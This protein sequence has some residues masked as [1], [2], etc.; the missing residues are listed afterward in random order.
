L[1]SSSK[2]W[3]D[4][5]L[6]ELKREYIIFVHRKLQESALHI[7]FVLVPLSLF[8]FSRELKKLPSDQGLGISSL[9]GPAS[10]QSASKV[11]SI[12]EPQQS[13]E[14]VKDLVMEV[15]KNEVMEDAAIAEKITFEEPA[16][17]ETVDTVPMEID[18]NI[19]QSPV[20]KIETGLVPTM[21]ESPVPKPER[22]IETDAVELRI[23]TESPPLEAKIENASSLATLVE[24]EVEVDDIPEKFPPQQQ[25]TPDTSANKLAD[26]DSVDTGNL[27]VY[28][29]LILIKIPFYSLVVNLLFR[30]KWCHRPG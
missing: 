23:K 18:T 16:A 22:A 2:D 5:K 7:Q 4:R 13:M 29:I 15:V 27:R 19:E 6:Q 30:N 21:A 14:V 9:A 26:T 20:S 17:T 12:N 8:S 11:N 1:K 24:K 3:L 25:H 10:L 28:Q